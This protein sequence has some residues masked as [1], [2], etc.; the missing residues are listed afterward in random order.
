MHQLFRGCLL[1]QSRGCAP[2]LEMLV[3][4]IQGFDHHLKRDMALQRD[5]YAIGA[6]KR[7]VAQGRYGAAEE[8]RQRRGMV[9]SLDLL[10]CPCPDQENRVHASLGT[11][12]DPC[13]RATD[14]LTAQR[15]CTT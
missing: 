11:S 7:A 5:A 12:L 10:A 14:A 2:L 6:E 8:E 3:C 4:V 9:H 13:H 1:L 15:R